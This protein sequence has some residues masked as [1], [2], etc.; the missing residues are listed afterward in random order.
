MG[1]HVD[2]VFS[3]AMKLD[4]DERARLAER[5]LDSLNPADAAAQQ[6][7]RAEIRKRIRDRESGQVEAVTSEEAR[8]RIFR[9]PDADSGQ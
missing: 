2:D 5:L 9:L 6:A 1:T 8:A 4:P 7:W 3:R